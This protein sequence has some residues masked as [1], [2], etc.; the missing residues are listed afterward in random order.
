MHDRKPETNPNETQTRTAIL[1]ETQAGLS[2]EERREIDA[3]I[4]PGV[5]AAAAEAAVPAT[6]DPA[7]QEAAEIGGS[8]KCGMVD[9]DRLLDLCGLAPSPPPP[10][11]PAVTPRVDPPADC[12]TKEETDCSP[13]VDLG[14]ASGEY[15]VDERPVPSSRGEQRDYD[16]GGR[17]DNPEGGAADVGAGAGS[18]GG[19]GDRDRTKGRTTEAAAVAVDENVLRR[20]THQADLYGR[21]LVRTVGGRKVMNHLYGTSTN[22]SSASSA[23]GRSKLS[24][25]SA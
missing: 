20:V 11:P 2:D 12:H 6:A 16:W 10:P 25:A 14:V 24:L 17:R 22:E 3:A 4:S 13:R 21:L 1:N 15:S 7:D 8:D 23:F 9:I 19:G 5:V 18:R